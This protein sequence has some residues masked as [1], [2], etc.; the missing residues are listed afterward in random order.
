MTQDKLLDVV[1]I[2][3]AKDDYCKNL[4]KNCIFSLLLSEDDAV[5]KFNIIVVESEKGIN[6]DYLAVNVKTYP[7]PLPYG[8]HKFLNFG[9][10]KGDSP[11]VAL[12]NNDLEFRDKWFTNI[13][14]ASE[15]SPDAM[16]FSPICPKTQPLY[17]IRENTGLLIEGYDIRKQISGWC[18]IQKRE[19]YDKIGDLDERFHHWYCDND[20][21]MELR[22]H[23]IKHLLVTNSVVIHHDKN[24]GKT[25]ERVVKDQSTMYNMTS[26]SYPIF[27][28]KWNL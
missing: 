25:T 13:L 22:K 11:W 28:A 9:R 12:C 21:A 26:G 7:A 20:Y 14:I 18:I 8:Y 27:K 4:T 10:K 1:I 6:W 19:I 5:D 3:Y 2:S 23:K 17:G 15:I 24:I 16:S